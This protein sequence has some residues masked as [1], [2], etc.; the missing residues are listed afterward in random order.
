[1]LAAA[2]SRGAAVLGARFASIRC[3][4]VCVGRPRDAPSRPMPGS[5]SWVRLVKAMISAVMVPLSL[6]YPRWS[7]SSVG[8]SGV[9]IRSV[10]GSGGP[11]R[12]IRCSVHICA[13]YAW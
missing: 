3:R 11:V 9:S 2:A 6:L 12:A 10:S 7:C 1:M 13:R 4:A 5:A 8:A